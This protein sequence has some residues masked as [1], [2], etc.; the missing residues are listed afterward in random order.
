MTGNSNLGSRRQVPMAPNFAWPN[1]TD[2]F[3]KTGAKEIARIPATL[4]NTLTSNSGKGLNWIFK[5]KQKM[6]T[7]ARAIST[8]TKKD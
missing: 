1:L 4:L 8:E 7:R 5:W 3:G 2:Q 6:A